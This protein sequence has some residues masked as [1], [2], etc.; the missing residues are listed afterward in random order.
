M[1]ALDETANPKKIIDEWSAKGFQP[2]AIPTLDEQKKRH[3]SVRLAHFRERDRALFFRWLLLLA[4][5]VDSLIVPA[6]AADMGG[7]AE[8]VSSTP[9][10]GEGDLKARERGA[11]EKSAPKKEKTDASDKKSNA[12]ETDETEGDR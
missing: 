6:E 8:V 9:A 5:G 2:V 4:T 12:S 11:A 3:Y 10:R 1:A 7:V